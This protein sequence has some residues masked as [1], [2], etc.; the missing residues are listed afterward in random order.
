MYVLGYQC[1]IF[2]IENHSLL[3]LFANITCL[4]KVRVEYP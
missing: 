3:V 1:Y 4:N 2:M